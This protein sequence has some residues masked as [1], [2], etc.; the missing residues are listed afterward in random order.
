MTL[1]RTARR[2]SIN[3]D[4]SPLAFLVARHSASL[5]RAADPSK[6]TH[7]TFARSADESPYVGRPGSRHADFRPHSGQIL[8]RRAK[9]MDR[10]MNHALLGVHTLQNRAFMP[11]TNRPGPPT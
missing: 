8:L 6:Q 5:A 4:P 11:I 1:P 9:A 10:I 2:G 7:S 3:S